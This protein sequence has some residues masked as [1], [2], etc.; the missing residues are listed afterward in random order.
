MILRDEGEVPLTLLPPP[1]PHLP[2][3]LKWLNPGYV[4]APPLPLPLPLLSSAD[5]G[6]M[7]MSRDPALWEGK[8]D[9]SL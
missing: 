9:D 4:D 7:T 3:G 2:S 8:S 6:G 5:G 1:W